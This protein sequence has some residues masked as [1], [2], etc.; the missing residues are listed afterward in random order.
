MESMPGD[1][2][3]ILGFAG[4]VG[5]I[6]I[7]PELGVERPGV[8]IQESAVADGYVFRM[9]PDDGLG[10]SAGKQAGKQQKPFYSP[11]ISKT[12]NRLPH[13]PASW[14][15]EWITPAK[16]AASWPVAILVLLST[17]Q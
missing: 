3:H 6:G 11:E 14:F 7:G 5:G 17:L 4:A 1:K 2:G 15:K 13:Q 9:V 12:C 16:Q 8:L 10:V